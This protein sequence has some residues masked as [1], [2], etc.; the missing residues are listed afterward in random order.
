MPSGSVCALQESVFQS[1]VS[2][3]SSIVGLMATS[4]KR[5]YA[6][7][8]LLHPEPLFLWQSSA[9][10]YLHRRHSNTV[11]SQ[12]L[13]SLWVLVHTKFEPSE[14]LWQEWGLILK[15]KLPLIPSCWGFSFALGCEVSPHSCS[16][17]AQPLLQCLPSC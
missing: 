17:A 7:P 13:W 2:S 6:I 9:D 15:V 16:S 8:S 4:S 1:C 14:H 12:S 11:L 10:L 5:A 3:G